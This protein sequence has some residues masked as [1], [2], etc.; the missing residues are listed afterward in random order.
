MEFRKRKGKTL[1]TPSPDPSEP[2]LEATLPEAPPAPPLPPVS[3]PRWHPAAR[4]ALYLVAF[5]VLQFALSFLLG[6]LSFLID[7][8]FATAPETLLA[9]VALQAPF[10]LG[11]THLFVRFLDRRPLAS[12]GARWPV[13]GR[14]AALRQL[15]M[16]PLGTLAL[17]GTWTALILLLPDSLAA[18]RF[19]GVS[20]AFSRGPSWWPLP[21]V[22]LLAVLFILF[23]IQGG[24]EEWVVRGYL[25]HVLKERW[26]PWVAA[27]VSS[28]LFSLF[29]LFNP[30]S[31][32]VALVNIL[33][34]GMILAALVERTGS[35]WSATL[36]HGVWNFVISC[37]LSLPVSGIRIFHLLDVSVTSDERLTGGGFGPEGSLVLTPLGLLLAVALWRGLGR[38]WTRRPAGDAPPSAPEDVVQSASL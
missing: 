5:V 18:I 9:F 32:A 6:A 20:A 8:R 4:A 11:M 22:L 23:L 19:G 33:L 7:D 35:L 27:L 38:D 36:A 17:I 37:L 13:G 3:R 34:A 2:A 31:S 16:A 21:P 24:L 30:D 14:P 28:I 29:H 12:L 15:V 1:E 25:Y 26:R 10:V